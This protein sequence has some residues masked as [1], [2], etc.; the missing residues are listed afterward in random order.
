MKRKIAALLVGLAVALGLTGVAASPAQAAYND[1]WT[2]Y[3]CLFDNPDGNG[4]LLFAAWSQPGTCINVPTSANDR[5]D[6]Y[7]NRLGVRYAQVYRDANCTG[8]ALHKTN[9]FGG[10]NQPF[11][12]AGENRQGSFINVDNVV[13]PGCGSPDHCDRNIATSIWFNNV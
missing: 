5:A 10:P 2:G 7:I 3:F 13:L 4:L 8:H 1:C 9:G 11:P 12:S 6:S